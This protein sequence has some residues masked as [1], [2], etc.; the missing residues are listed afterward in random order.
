MRDLG[1]HITTGVSADASTLQD[2]MREA[3][4]L[5]FKVGRLPMDYK[6]RASIIRTRVLP[7]MLYGSEVS[8]PKEALVEAANAAILNW[9]TKKTGNKSKPFTSPLVPMAVTST[10]KSAYS[11][12]ES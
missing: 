12:G 10:S 9:V 4:T 7:K 1:A 2:R 5:L 8:Q 3:T 6:K 11:T